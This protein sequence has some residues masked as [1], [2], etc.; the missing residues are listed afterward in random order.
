VTLHRVSKAPAA[1][2][3]PPAVLNAYE[4]HPP[5]IPE[6]VP[7]P[8]FSGARVFRITGEHSAWCLKALPLAD[9]DLVRQAGLQRL[10]RHLA[11]GGLNFIAPPR[12][13][14][15][16]A[17]WVV[18]EDWLWQC[19][20]WLPG[21]ADRSERIA[22]GRL[23]AACQ[24]LAVWHERARQFL[25][26]LAE[27]TWFRS[28][29]A[30]PSPAARERAARLRETLAENLG[31]LQ[32][33]AWKQLP[34]DLHPAVDIIVGE[35]RRR[36]RAV[37]GELERWQSRPL[38]IQ[39]CLRDVWREHV[40]F[41]QDRVTGLIDPQAARCDSPAVDLARLLGS[42]CGSDPEAWHQGLNAYSAIRPLSLIESSLIPVLDQS[43]CLLAGLHWIGRL[44]RSAEIE[45]DGLTAAKD[46][47]WHFASRLAAG[48]IRIDGSS[49]TV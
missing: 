16:G 39:P 3:L 8:G 43:G 45:A 23:R 7:R 28:H 21:E 18:G 30:E 34:A 10:Q 37:A 46:R 47:L 25:P 42:L 40:L 31:E 29:P 1:A 26:T 44:L 15:A 38:P 4:I 2:S 17:P 41:V 48:A 6:A 5:S 11:A 22:P 13:T 20:R 9:V 36:G 14:Q 32:A 49:L 19:E 33:R 35:V 24:A 12:L 27:A